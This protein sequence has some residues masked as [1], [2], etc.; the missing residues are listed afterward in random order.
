MTKWQRLILL[1]GLSASPS[2]CGLDFSRLK[3]VNGTDSQVVGLTVS[4]GQKTWK[5]SDLARDEQVTFSGHLSGEG[6]A[7]INWTWRGQRLL[8]YWRQSSQRHDNNYRRQ[9]TLSLRVRGSL[10]MSAM[11]ENGH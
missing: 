8:L 3:F 10:L 6:G 9:T 7:T 4:D 11:V 1:I 5:L 2:S